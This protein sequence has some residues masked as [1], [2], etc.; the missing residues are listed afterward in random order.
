MALRILGIDLGTSSVKV[1]EL[2]SSF[3]SLELVSLKR[4]PVTTEDPRRAPALSEQLAALSS[5]VEGGGR[6]DVVV[7]AL[8]GA[9][10]ATHRLSLPFADLRRLEQTLGFEVEGQI[11]FDLADV[12]YDYEVLSQRS[13]RGGVL[14]RTEV[15]V[16]V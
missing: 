4:A 5:L 12:R 1:S 13:A 3:R 7:V 9:G 8:P 11:P 10:A 15:L 14:A 6:P 2:R 16:G